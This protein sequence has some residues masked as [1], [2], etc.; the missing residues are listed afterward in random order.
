MNFTALRFTAL[1][2]LLA[3]GGCFEDK[4]K[5]T[6]A[7]PA[8]APVAATPAPAS[9][10]VAAPAVAPAAPAT[11]AQAAPAKSKAAKPAPAPAPKAAPCD[12]CGVVV[13]V[14]VI[15]EKGKGSGVGAIAGGVAGGVLGHQVGDGTGKDV[16]TAVG[17]VGG[18]IIGNKIEQNMKKTKVWDVAVKLDASGETRILRHATD[19]GVTAGSKVKIVNDQV[20][21]Q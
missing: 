8:A 5:E 16:A 3:L 2:S 10:P 13:S 14:N 9:T 20:V 1:I 11:I 19:P 12:N 7:T 18:A 17:V 21:K 15:E 6:A 4:P